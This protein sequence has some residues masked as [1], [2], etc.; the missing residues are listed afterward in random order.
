M[1]DRTEHAA[2]Y[3]SA[4]HHLAWLVAHD[5]VSE[6]ALAHI[7]VAA[8]LCEIVDLTDRVT[9]EGP[10]DR[11]V[12]GYLLAAADLL[13][14][15]DHDSGHPLGEEAGSIASRLRELAGAA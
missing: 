11:H 12:T 5:P 2:G 15:V 13:D 1:T 7:D 6:R 9:D 3:L 14:L 8:A 4:I 10:E